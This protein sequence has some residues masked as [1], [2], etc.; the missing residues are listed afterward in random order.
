V[1]GTGLPLIRLDFA[2]CMRARLGPRAGLAEAALRPYLK[3]GNDVLAQLLAEIRSGKM[4][5][6]ELP[7]R[8]DLARESQRIAHRHLK[9]FDTLLVL[10]MGGSALGARGLIEA[11]STPGAPSS[12][13]RRQAGQVMILDTLEPATVQGA[14]RGVDPART[15]VNVVSKS[16]DTLETAALF[17]LVRERFGRALG[18][19]ELPRHLIFTVGPERGVLGAWAT[20]S[21]AE[22]VEM[23][24]G[25]GGRFSVLTQVGLLPAAFAG[26]D[27]RSVVSGASAMADI[28]HLAPPRR[29]PAFLSAVLLLV[30]RDRGRECQIVFH[31]GRSLRGLAAWYGQLW[32][33]SLGKRHDLRGR[34]V[35]WGQT[36]VV[37]EGPA[38]QHSLLQLLLEGPDDKVTGLW[39]VEQ[40]SEDGVL[41]EAENGADG[42][43]RLLAGKKLADLMRVQ[44]AST[45]VALARAGRPNFTWI[46][47]QI[48]PHVA[49]QLIYL[50]E[51]QTVIAARLLGINA[52]DQPAVEFGKQVAYALLGGPVPAEQKR[53][54]RR[55]GE[56]DPRYVV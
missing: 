30:E 43:L 10:G 54:I 25:V 2:N 23:P 12:G 28:C 49:G 53:W 17:G 15:L 1:S 42:V 33:E 14:L 56:R 51:Y 5:F 16:G 47:P 9:H 45:A 31:Y 44:K 8:E 20:A 6:A 18:A 55:A 50:L 21:G 3:R 36:P 35:E 7:S 41:P 38:D 52:F 26:V 40:H 22:I 11:L 19:A 29:N 24:A 4:A 34:V 27:V 48:T 46:L 39:E 13:A 37:A 32:A